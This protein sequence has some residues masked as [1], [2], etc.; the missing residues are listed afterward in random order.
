MHRQIPRRRHFDVIAYADMEA[1]ERV[2]RDRREA[3]VLDV[4]RHLPGQ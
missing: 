1:A 3:V 2:K 4:V